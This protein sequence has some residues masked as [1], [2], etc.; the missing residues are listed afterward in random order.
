MCVCSALD[1]KCLSSNKIFKVDLSY[2]CDGIKHTLVLPMRILFSTNIDAILGRE[3]IK[4]VESGKPISAV[5]LHK[6]RG[7]LWNSPTLGRRDSYLR[8]SY[9]KDREEPTSMGRHW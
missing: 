5:L 4:K 7:K 1:G 6:E 3:I 8:Y 9:N 2:F